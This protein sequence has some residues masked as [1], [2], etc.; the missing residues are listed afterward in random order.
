MAEQ[1][2]IESSTGA[3]LTLERDELCLDARTDAPR[4]VVK[5]RG[6]SPYPDGWLVAFSGDYR[7][8]NGPRYEKVLFGVRHD[9][10]YPK[11][12]K[13]YEFCVFVQDPEGTED[14]TMRCVLRV[15][16]KRLEVFGKTLATYSG[17]GEFSVGVT[18]LYRELLGR[19][20]ESA[21]VIEGWRV[22]SD[23]NLALVRQGIMGSPEYK[24]KHP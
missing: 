7:P 17:P 6:S 9:D 21:A 11:D 19:D 23:G 2:L 18:L 24:A 5:Y 3:R 4:D 22:Y 12:V 8:E 14:E 16:S 15:S 13:A 20:P 1:H 10:D